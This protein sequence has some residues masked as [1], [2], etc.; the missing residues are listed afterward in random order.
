MASIPRPPVNRIAFTQFGLTFLIAT[1]LGLMVDSTAAWS[2][3]SGG[4]ICAIPNGYF[5]WRAFRYSGAQ[6]TS[7][8][9]PAFYQGEAWKFMLTALGFAAVFTSL[10]PLN[11]WA[12]FGS[13]VAVQFS[14]VVATH[15]LKL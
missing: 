15:F 10:D 3:L 5:I 9:V 12:L 11:V 1:L 14:H 2:A 8:I 7:R 13:F 4:L 6:S